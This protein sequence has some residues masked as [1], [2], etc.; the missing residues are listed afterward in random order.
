MQRWFRL[1]SMLL[2]LTAACSVVLAQDYVSVRGSLPPGSVRVFVRDTVY[3]I[4]GTYAIGGTLIIEPG[5]RIEFLPNGRLIDS[6][7]G[8]IIADGRASATYTANAANALFPPYTGYDDPAYFGATGVLTSTIATEPTIHSSKY[9]TI[10]NVNLGSDPNLQNLTPAK[11]M[12]YMAARLSLGTVIST[13]RLNPWFREKAGTAINVRPAR[14]TFIAGDV[15]NFSREW[16]HIVVLPGARAAFFR[17]VDFLNFRKDTTVDNQSVYLAN[18]SGTQFSAAQAASANDNLLRATNGSGGAITTFSIRTWLVGCTFRNNTARYHGGAL[19]ILQA[20]V[21]QFAGSSLQLYPVV[22]STTMAALPKY[23][24]QTNSWLTNPNTAQPYDQQ[25][26][27]LDWLFDSGAEPSLTDVD[28]Q[29]IDDARLA[30][31]LGRIRQLRFINNRVLLSDVDTVRIGGVRVVT[32]ADRAATVHANIDR[33]RKNDAFGGALYISGRTPMTIGLGINDFQGKDTMEFTS[34]YAENRQ[35]ST[36]AGN[37]VTNGARGGAI[38]LG[39]NTS[40]VLTGR[41]TTNKTTAPY[42]PNLSTANL[43]NANAT[44]SHGGAIYA[45]T[46]AMQLQ[47]RGGLDNNPPTHFL[48]NTSGRGGA[49]YVSNNNSDPVPS[50][51]VGGSDG[52]INARNYGYNIKF[53]DNKAVASGGAIHTERNMFMYG[54]GGASGPLWIYGTNY[55]VELSNNTAG[56]NGGGIA[57]MLPSELPISRRNLRFIRAQFVNNRVG[58]VAD[59]LK[60]I[61]RGGGGL[62]SINADLNVVKGVEFRANKVWNGNGGAVAVVTPDTLTRRRFMVTDLDDVSFNAQGVATGYTPRNDVFTF[63]TTAPGADERMLTRFYDNMA[64]PNPARQGSGTTQEGDIKFMHP[65]TT[66]R[67]NGTGLG[68]A[69]YILDS[70]RVRVDTF[71]FDRV[72]IQGNVAH[73]GAAIYSDNFD[74]KLALTRTLITNNKATSTTGRSNDTIQGPLFNNEFPAS[75]DLAGAVLYGEVV[76]PLPWTTYSTA[77]NSIYDNDARF[78]IRLPDAQDTK[79]VLAGTTGIGFGGVDTL[80]GN[81][82]GQ[83]E[84]NVNTILPITANQTFQRVQETFFIAGNGKTH[85]GFVRN[86]INPN[87][88]GPFESTWR[89]TYKAIPTWQIP[90]TLLMEGRIYDIFDKGTDIKTADY[91]NRRMSPVEDF[92]VGIPPTMKLFSNSTF[93]SFNKY[94][95]RMTRNPFDADVD[96]VIA[97]VQT[98]F[99]GTHPIGYPLFLEARADYSATSEISNNDIRAINESVYFVINERTGDFIRVNMKQIGV[100]DTV[101][102]ARVELVPDS[103][104]GGDPNIRR[105]Y[106]GLATY[107]SGATLLSFLN[108]NA[109]R[110]DSGAFAGRRWSGSTANGELGGANFRLGNRPSLPLS[111]TLPGDGGKETYFGGERYRAL[112]VIAGDRVTIVSRTALWKKGII[113]AINGSLTFTVSNT[114]NPPVFTGAADTLGTSTKLHPTFR[115]RVF[116]TENRLYTPITAAQSRRTDGNG[117]W[118]SEPST[119]GNGERDTIFTI[120]AKDTNKFY[121]PRVITDSKLNSQLSYFWSILTPNSALRYWLRDTLVYASSAVNPKWGATGYRMLRGRPINPYIVPGGEEVEVVAK[122]YPPSVELVDSLRKSGWSEQQISKWIYLYPSYYHAQEYHNNALA[123]N[124]RD[125]SNTNARF[126]QQDTVNFGWFDTTAYKFKIHVVDSMPRFLWAHRAVGNQPFNEMLK[127]DTTIV[128]D[129]TTTDSNVYENGVYLDTLRMKNT[130]SRVGRRFQQP[131][132]ITDEIYNASGPNAGQADTVNI[133]F[134]ANLTDSLRFLVDVNTDDEFEDMAS[135]DDSRFVVKQFGKWDFRYGKT[136]YGFLS[137]SIHETPGDTT[138]DELLAARP[139]WMANQYLR[140]Y[141]AAE[142]ADPFAQDLTTSGKINIRIDA[143]T[144]LQILKPVNDIN[145]GNPINGDL[146]TDTLM[147]IVVNDGHGG[148]N[149]LTRRLFINVQ[150]KIT[151]LSLEDALED[152]DYN[153]ALL[154]SNR[155]IRVYDPNFGQNHTFKLIYIDAPDDTMYIDPYFRESGFIAIDA[156]KKTTPKWLMID[157]F[158][159]LLYGTP[160]VTDVPFSDTTVQVTALVQDPGGLW[161]IVTVSLK[162][163]AV[164]HNPR[165]LASPIVK[166]VDINKPYTDTIKVTDIDLRRTQASNEE[167]TFAV[168][169]PAGG[170]WTFTP[171]KLSSPMSDTATIVISNTSFSGPVENGK[172]TIQIE[173]TDKQGVKDT[174]TYKVAVSAETR[175]TVDISVRNYQGGFQLLTFGLG[176][177]ERATRGDE[178]NSYGMLDSNY[179]EYELPNVPPEDVFDARWTIPNRNGILRNIYPFSNQAGESVFRARFQAGGE[180]SQ[181]SAYYP[182]TLTWCKSQIPAV[183][184]TNPGSYYIRDDFSNGANFSYNMKT[185]KGRSAADI[186]HHDDSGRAECDTIIIIRDALRGFIIVYD[187]TTDVNDEVPVVADGLAITKTSPNP[188][189][190]S[191]N[192]AFS[193]PATSRVTVEVYNSVGTKVATLANQVY[194]VGQYS[195]E[196]NAS[197]VSNGMY[198]VRI[199]D[200]SKSVTQQVSVVK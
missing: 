153:V 27:A 119:Y 75:S 141:N 128:L 14:I 83:T 174:L 86:S 125:P 121:D 21:D 89:I 167:L 129:P 40:L 189:A 173:V 150:P 79:G 107:G 39:D 16:G 159:G 170:T 2:V 112:P 24:A 76:G 168:I 147:T 32:D 134:V 139:I 26:T 65:G 7:G 143:A 29:S 154:D 12:V 13:I 68:G 113:D 19:Q 1:S 30:V 176:G 3:R 157:E 36:Q 166:C 114:T 156:S 11:A 145:P 138:L 142:T 136:A 179:C 100:T 95:K 164:N 35:P 183:D 109:V 195:I 5:T 169:K 15:N 73:S 102:R 194:G 106:E 148:I 58:D 10:F 8:R 43:A 80:R 23:S 44:Y 185:G 37:Q 191:T 59:S 103:T 17:D 140:K 51:Y 120:T 131:N 92:A 171:N 52:I 74:L 54:A 4:S 77:A 42:I 152:T 41:F 94:V 199:S 151:T 149:A 101:Y 46:T 192:I 64:Y 62:Y 78:T 88:Q 161:D 132:A 178:F 155:R 160:R 130:M 56:Y 63:G 53:R 34:N 127:G 84:V 82:W 99:V 20:P 193:V 123:L 135:V 165:L 122:N 190:T 198:T 98:E 118:F 28:R 187:Y 18:S 61:V 57:A 90:D 110:E 71:G 186:L 163:N 162:I 137:T 81:Y 22:S 116:I 38:Y 158:S 115:N 126:L 33:S 85:L 87:D 181:S 66:L 6:T 180:N 31:Y 49:V 105:A 124:L 70:V 9:G 117:S 67:E 69:L 91:S 133:Q 25:L 93:P 50:P 177:S 45:S 96:T 108:R 111:N 184:A 72:R 104:R 55:G 197:G 146:N 172:V 182:V 188:F 196:W 200:G 97:K 47:I 144:A 175:F 60:S 48:G